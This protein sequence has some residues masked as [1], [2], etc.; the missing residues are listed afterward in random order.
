MDHVKESYLFD[1]KL[2]LLEDIQVECY[3]YFE[4]DSNWS[5]TLERVEL[6]EFIDICFI[7]ENHFIFNYKRDF[8]YWGNINEFLKDNC[9]DMSI[10]RDE[11]ISN[12]LKF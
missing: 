5:S 12:I 3:E 2:F 8:I 4:Y 9:K 11:I 10:V 1:N 7:G 6:K